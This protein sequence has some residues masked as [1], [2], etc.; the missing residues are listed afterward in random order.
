MFQFLFNVEAVMI[1]LTV[2]VLLFDLFLFGKGNQTLSQV[3][4]KYS[5][6]I[7][8]IPFIGGFLAGHL[9]G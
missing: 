5:R 4:I 7:P 9:W 6:D 3:I 8:F 2:I 1:G